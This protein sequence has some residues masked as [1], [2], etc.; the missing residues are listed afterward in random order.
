MR[1]LI[2][3]WEKQYIEFFLTNTYFIIPFLPLF[4]EAKAFQIKHLY[5]DG[6]NLFYEEG[7][8]KYKIDCSS[9]YLC[10]GKKIIGEYDT[11]NIARK[12]EDFRERLMQMARAKSDLPLGTIVIENT[13]R[14]TAEDEIKRLADNLFSKSEFV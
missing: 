13:R 3:S 2:H 9:L 8:K 11:K 10:F 4:G 7:G 12:I 14:V 5:S 6:K 1:K